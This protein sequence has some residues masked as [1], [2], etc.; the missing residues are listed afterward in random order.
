MHYFFSDGTDLEPFFNDTEIKIRITQGTDWN[1]LLAE[2]STK[3]L[4]HFKNRYTEG[5]RH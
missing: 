3:T 2:G 4:Q 1:K 5:Q